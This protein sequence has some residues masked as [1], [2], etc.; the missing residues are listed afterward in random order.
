MNRTKHPHACD[1]LAFGGLFLDQEFRFVDSIE[2]EGKGIVELAFREETRGKDLTL[3]PGG[4]AA[5]TSIQARR[6]G[7]E[8]RILGKVGTDPYASLLLDGLEA[9]GINI[10]GVISSSHYTGTTVILSGRRG[11]SL[12]F[13]MITH[14][15]ANEFLEASEIVEPLRPIES[16]LGGTVVFFGD[17]FAVARLQH[18]LADLFAYLKQHNVTLALDHGRFH[19]ARTPEKVIRHLESAMSLVDIYLPSEMEI[20]EFSGRRT[21]DE[22]LTAVFDAYP[23]KVVAVKMGAK[24]CRIRTRRDDVTVPAFPVTE[25]VSS[26]GAGDAF[27]AAFLHQ[28]ANNPNDLVAVGRMANA[29]GRLKIISG[30]Y[31]TKARVMTFLEKEEKRTQP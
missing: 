31:P 4:S 7:M 3:S 9:E 6:F 22:A 17:F 19:R 23:L 27:N 13:A 26:L 20:Q 14:N 28:F 5:N 1:L 25:G 21:L 2:W 16:E 29:T 10:E 30:Q 24:G 12:E 18:E 11:D 15:G 8:V